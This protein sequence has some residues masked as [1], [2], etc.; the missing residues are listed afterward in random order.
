MPVPK[1]KVSRS[2]RDKRSANKGI[3]V[4]TMT[5]CATC[6]APA[7]PHRI[8]Q[9]CGYYKG[10]KIIRTKTERFYERNKEKKQDEMQVKAQQT[11]NEQQDA[12]NQKAI[13]QEENK[14][15]KE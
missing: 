15:E 9:E 6:Q 2:R 14:K 5:R 11:L 7:V 1:R 13:A 4:M 3:S 8:C 10:E 12:S